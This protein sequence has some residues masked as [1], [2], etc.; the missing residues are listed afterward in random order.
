MNQ[1][2]SDFLDFSADLLPGFHSQFDGLP[3]VL[4]QNAQDRIASLQIDLAL[5]EQL[6]ANKSKGQDKS[7]GRAFHN[8]FVLP[9]NRALC[10]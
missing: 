8:C 3:R 2:V 7:E 10:Q 6:G 9:K 5:R 4:L 1:L